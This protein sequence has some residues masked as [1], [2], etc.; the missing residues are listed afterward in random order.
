[1]HARARL[2]ESTDLLL[3]I[4]GEARRATPQEHAELYQQRLSELLEEHRAK[5]CACPGCSR[6][7]GSETGLPDPDDPYGDDPRGDRDPQ[8]P[9]KSS[10]Q[11]T[12][13]TEEVE[14]QEVKAEE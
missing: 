5:D 11:E 4:N 14:E 8:P 13:E 2:G 7:E 1:M 9:P 10:T 3:P 12:E 6:Y